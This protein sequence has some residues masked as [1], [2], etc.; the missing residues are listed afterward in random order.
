VQVRVKGQILAPGMQDGDHSRVGP[1]KIGVG[2]K[3]L[4]HLPG[5][6]EQK[7]IDRFGVIKAYPVKFRWKGKDHMEVRD[8]QQFGLPCPDP[9]FPFVSLALGTVAVPATVVAKVQPMAVRVVATVDMPAQCCG[10][11]FAQG[12]QGP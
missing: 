5:R 11:A 12:V 4:D 2:R 3:P 9:L 6:R 7:V 1:Q 10:T 8:V